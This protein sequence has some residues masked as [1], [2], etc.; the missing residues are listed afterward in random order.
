MR[1][2]VF[3]ID[4]MNFKCLGHEIFPNDIYSCEQ[5]FYKINFL[6]FKMTINH[7]KW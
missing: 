6:Q 4:I 5:W 7:C 1:E 2:Y 3:L